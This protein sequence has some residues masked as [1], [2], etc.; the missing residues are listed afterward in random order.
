LPP[1]LAHIFYIVKINRKYGITYTK[2]VVYDMSRIHPQ[3]IQRE[4]KE[5]RRKLLI[6]WNGLLAKERR[7]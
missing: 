7:D 5:Y 4:R 2:A 3:P 6:F 1:L